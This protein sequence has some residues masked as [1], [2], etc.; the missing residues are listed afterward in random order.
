M[1]YTIKR[2]SLFTIFFMALLLAVTVPTNAFGQGRGHSRSRHANDWKCGKFVNC[3]DARDGR[4]DGRGP[5]V[6]WN[7][8]RWRNSRWS[9]N[10][11]RRRHVRTRYVRQD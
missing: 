1:S 2:R 6:G 3:H 7:Q 4:L 10:N 8:R 11:D 9:N 5:R